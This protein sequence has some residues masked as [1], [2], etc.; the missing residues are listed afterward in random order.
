MLRFGKLVSARRGTLAIQPRSS[1][2]R[3]G[4]GPM[5]ARWNRYGMFRAYVKN[6]KI[7]LCI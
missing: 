3:D 6:K 7:M 4:V 1:G 2:S 5:V